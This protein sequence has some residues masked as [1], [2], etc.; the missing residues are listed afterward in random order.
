MELPRCQTELIEAVAA[1]GTPFVLVLFGGSPCACPAAYASA[2]AVIQA[3]YPGELGGRALARILFGAASPS[4]RLP[5]TIPESTNQLLPMADYRMAG[6]TYRYMDGNA[7][8]WFG[9]G[10]SYTSFAY[11]NLCLDREVIQSGE[12]LTVS[13]KVTNAGKR[14]GEEVVQLYLAHEADAEGPRMRLETFRRLHL[15]AGESQLLTLTLE[16]SAFEHIGSDGSAIRARGKLRLWVGGDSPRQ[17]G[18]LC[19]TATCQIE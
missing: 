13:V 3:F 11:E 1:T 7:T 8:Y 15:E 12:L 5:I 17:E 10:L 14:A 19:Q 16:E 4:G 18:T 9:H 2:S 6:R